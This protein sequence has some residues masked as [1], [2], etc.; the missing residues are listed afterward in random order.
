MVKMLEHL[1]FLNLV[2]GRSVITSHGVVTSLCA[3]F[4]DFILYQFLMKRS[5]YQRKSLATPWILII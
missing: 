5:K 4:R 2:R 1:K 3:D